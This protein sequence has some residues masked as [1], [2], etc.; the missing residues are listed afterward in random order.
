MPRNGVPDIDTVLPLIDD[1]DKDWRTW[2][3]L[4]KRDLGGR[5]LEM[6][7]AG[8][9]NARLLALSD[10]ERKR[11]MMVVM[12]RVS[13]VDIGAGSG[14]RAGGCVGYVS[15]ELYLIFFYLLIWDY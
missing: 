9:A 6:V 2:S 14:E 7:R 15:V 3:E 12:V 13:G 10:K 5:A 8:W 1:L 4:S 11:R